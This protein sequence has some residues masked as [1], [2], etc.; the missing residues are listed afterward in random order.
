MKSKWTFPLFCHL[1][2]E[3]GSSLE[4]WEKD[5]EKDINMKN[6]YSIK[7]VKVLVFLCRMVYTVHINVR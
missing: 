1:E 3:H 4:R 2:A 7:R 5:A 6:R